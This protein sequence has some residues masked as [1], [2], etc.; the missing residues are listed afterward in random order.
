MKKD[1]LVIDDLRVFQFDAVYARTSEEAIALLRAQRCWREVWWDFDLG[2][3]PLGGARFPSG[4]QVRRVSNDTSVEV[5]KYLEERW[6]TD[7]DTLRE[8]EMH[9]I[10]TS[11][12]AGERLLAGAF[13]RWGV[14]YRRRSGRVSYSILGAT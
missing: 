11:N 7:L 12:P 3:N 13:D 8:I 4:M 9:N 6:W 2:L 1:V 10:V 14:P 5:L